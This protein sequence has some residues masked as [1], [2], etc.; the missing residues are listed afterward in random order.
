MGIPLREDFAVQLRYSA[1]EQKITLPAYLNDCNNI[2]PDF[3]STFPTPAALAA[4]GAA[5]Y[6]GS[7]WR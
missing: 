2:N 5:A 6:P 1:Y 7:C 4:G 3:A